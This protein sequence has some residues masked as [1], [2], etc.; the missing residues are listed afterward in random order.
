[1]KGQLRVN[2]LIYWMQSGIF[3][4]V[5]RLPS[6]SLCTDVKPG[7][8]EAGPPVL[9]RGRAIKLLSISNLTVIS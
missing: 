2:L 3:P 8:G 4:V 1:M 9:A 6:E 7:S 5:C